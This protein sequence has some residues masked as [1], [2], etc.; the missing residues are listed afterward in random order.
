MEHEVRHSFASTVEV[1]YTSTLPLSSSLDAQEKSEFIAHELLG[2][3]Q[4][5][6]QKTLL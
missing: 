5:E 2:T 6:S 4:L 3:S 1:K